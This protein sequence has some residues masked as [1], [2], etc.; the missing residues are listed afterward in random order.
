MLRLRQRHAS[1]SR[2]AA[3]DNDRY[4]WTALTNT[5]A[6]SFMATVDGSGVAV[7]P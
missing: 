6:G 3:R 2:D 1:M 4:K 5:S 7:G